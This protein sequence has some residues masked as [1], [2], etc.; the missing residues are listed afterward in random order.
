MGALPLRPAVYRERAPCHA[1]REHVRALFHFALPETA[2][3]AAAASVCPALFADAGISIVF[4]VAR[5]WAVDGLWA[6]GRRGAPGYVVGPMTRGWGTSFG[7][8]VDAVGAYLRAGSGAALLGVPPSVLADRIVSV[9]ELWP[10]EGPAL[11]DAIEAAPDVD[12]RLA[13][14]ERAL[15]R[16]LPATGLD[17]PLIDLARAID[18]GAGPQT[19][20]DLAYRAGLS[21]QHLTR[22]FRAAMGVPPKLFCRLSRFHRLLREAQGGTAR[23]DGGWAGAAAACG[24]T[25]QSHMIAEFKA[26]TGLTPAALLTS[27]GFHP[28]AEVPFLL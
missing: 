11:A 22:R 23:A 2:D 5:G 17:R 14:L 16:H 21:R 19:V 25:D 28:F 3:P 9:D 8:R 26:F 24:Y 6:P 7:T 13:L 12:T 1:L 27:G 10:V 4:E 20:D 15:V 18:R